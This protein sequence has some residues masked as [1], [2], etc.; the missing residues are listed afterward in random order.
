MKCLKCAY[1]FL[2]GES[3]SGPPLPEPPVGGGGGGAAAADISS[4]AQC[5]SSQGTV[6]RFRIYAIRD[7]NKSSVGVVASIEITT[8]HVPYL[9]ILCRFLVKTFTVGESTKQRH[10]VLLSRFHIEFDSAPSW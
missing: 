3:W 7:S 1:S 9:F 2:P 10:L 4:G 5:W 6:E 8:A